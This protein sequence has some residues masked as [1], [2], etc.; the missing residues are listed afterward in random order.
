MGPKQI[1]MLQ[2]R[3]TTK[4]ADCC[5]ATQWVEKCYPMQ[6]DSSLLNEIVEVFVTLRVTAPIA[7]G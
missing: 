3:L 1:A 4:R 5:F 2:G 6:T 7:S